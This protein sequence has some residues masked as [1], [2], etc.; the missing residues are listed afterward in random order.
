MS[1]YKTICLQEEILKINLNI[2]FLYLEDIKKHYEKIKV[3]STFNKKKIYEAI[4]DEAMHLKCL[5][6]YVKKDYK[7]MK[8]I[9]YLLIKIDNIIFFLL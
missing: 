6:K 3:K 1:F 9:V 5:I 7:Q 4:V 8:E 2:F